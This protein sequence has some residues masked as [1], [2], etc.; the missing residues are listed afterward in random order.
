MGAR[1]R[2]YKA[3]PADRVGHAYRRDTKRQPSALHGGQAVAWALGTDRCVD[4]INKGAHKGG[5]F[6][7]NH[8]SPQAISDPQLLR[9]LSTLVTP[10][11]TQKDIVQWDYG[12]WPG[13]L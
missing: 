7:K 5:R 4:G 3:C 1:A 12:S 13:G 8:R 9:N 2:A 11:A 6:A 10:N